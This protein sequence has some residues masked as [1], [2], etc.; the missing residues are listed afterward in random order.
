MNTTAVLKYPGSKW[1]I[2]DWII[3]HMPAHEVYLEPYFGSGAVFF[4]KKLVK[5]ETINDLEGNVVNLFRVIREMPQAL[6]DAFLVLCVYL[7]LQN[8]LLWFSQ[9]Q[10]LWHGWLW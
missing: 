9:F 1:S 8:V 3:D 7:P 10:A 4:R 2:A 6:A 5:F